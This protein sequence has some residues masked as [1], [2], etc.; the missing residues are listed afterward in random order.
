MTVTVAPKLPKWDVFMRLD[1]KV[2]RKGDV[3]AIY[4]E[5]PPNLG[6]FRT[7][8][9]LACGKELRVT[10]KPEDVAKLLDE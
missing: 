4:P 10:A 5:P 1:D 2:I 8:I 3:S 7:V 9:L 6:T